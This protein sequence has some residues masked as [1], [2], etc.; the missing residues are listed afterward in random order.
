MPDPEDR[1]MLPSPRRPWAVRS[2]AV[3][4]LPSRLL[5]PIFIVELT[6]VALVVRSA[7]TM[8]LPSVTEGLYALVIGAVGL[9]HTELAIGI[10]R[11]RR[12]VTDAN[13]VD[14]SS[15]W[16]FAAAIV[17]PPSLAALV[18][19]CLQGHIWL[20][21]AR[22]RLLLYRQC[23][24]ASTVVLACL[25]ASA[26]HGTPSG[27][28]EIDLPAIVLALLIY[29]S[30]NSG[31]IAGAIA[32][33]T[34]QP[35]MAKVFGQWDDN[36]LEIATLSLGGLTAIALLINP[37]LVLLVLPPL[38][39]L[40]RAVLV[41]HLEEAASTDSKT[42]LLNAATWHSRVERELRR[43]NRNDRSS[44]VLVLDLD[45]F[46]HVNDAHGH[47]AG[48]IVLTAI[49]DTLRSE[50]RER[51]LVGRFGGEEFVVFLAGPHGGNAEVARIA[52]RIRRRVAALLVEIP[53]PDGPLTIGG[54]SVSVGAAL[55][56]DHGTDLHTL[57]RI[58]DAAL[59]GAKR[60]GRNVV[61]VGSAATSVENGITA[62][63]RDR[64]PQ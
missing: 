40:H 3:W 57:L 24:T 33:S 50:T 62:A 55:H 18:A 61:C 42:G 6:A 16:T 54:I 49:A 23:F 58:A 48:D 9:A 25:A 35:D 12:R 13:H 26:V 17:L 8:P 36:V 44:A 51:D 32:L 21:T 28:S 4:E 30:V 47:L 60:A 43:S 29:T 15:V 2:W 27:V 1:G 7:I 19:A 53:T 20:R 38:L 46:K 10:E 59:Y 45:H 56:P 31:L 39:V 5:A 64:K 37:L 11:V 22:P 34:P 41:R 14:L 52:E 63:W